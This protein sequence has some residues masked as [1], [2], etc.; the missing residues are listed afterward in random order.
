M[1]AMPSPSGASASQLLALSAHWST[2]AVGVVLWWPWL[3]AQHPHGHLLIPPL[4]CGVGE[5]IGRVRVR[6]LVVR[7]KFG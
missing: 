6:R 4:S 7:I 5:K 2:A 3:A 1:A